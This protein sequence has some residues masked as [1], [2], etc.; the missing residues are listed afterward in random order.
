[1]WVSG[2]EDAMKPKYVIELHSQK[3][4]PRRIATVGKQEVETF[5]QI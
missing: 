4:N 3:P 2:F 1:M 5:Q